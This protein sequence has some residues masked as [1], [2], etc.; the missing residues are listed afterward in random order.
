MADLGCI[1]TPGVLFAVLSPP[2]STLVRLCQRSC[3][4]LCVCVCMIIYTCVYI[5]PSGNCLYPPTSP[6][7]NTYLYTYIHMESLHRGTL[8][9]DGDHAFWA[10]LYL[11]RSLCATAAKCRDHFSPFCACLYAMSRVRQGHTL[12]LFCPW[13]EILNSKCL[14]TFTQENPYRVPFLFL[15]ISAPVEDL[16]DR[17]DLGIK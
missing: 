1:A 17:P 8:S 10:C 16:A 13:A 3:N 4:L 2:P 15:R 6:C 5:Y 14:S 12:H 9:R 11:P 7:A